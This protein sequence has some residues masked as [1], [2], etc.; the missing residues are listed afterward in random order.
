MRETTNAR[1]WAPPRPGLVILVYLF[2]LATNLFD[3]HATLRVIQVGVDEWNPL[4]RYVLQVGPTF[5]VAVKTVGIAV[6]GGLIALYA[7][8]W[9]WTWWSLCLL[10]VAYFALFAAHVAFLLIIKPPLA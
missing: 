5:F 1:A 8:R 2:L 9:R 6:L 7:R 3:A 10:A 4:M